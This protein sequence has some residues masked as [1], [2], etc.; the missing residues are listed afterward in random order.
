MR[1][2]RG[3]DGSKSDEIARFRARRKGDEHVSALA[4]PDSLSPLTGV[5]HVPPQSRV[6]SRHTLASYLY[7]P[8][9]AFPSASS[10][11]SPDFVFALL[12][13]PRRNTTQRSN[14][15][16]FQLLRTSRNYH[17]KI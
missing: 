10:F 8:S 16:H 3:F 9:S 15:N 11:L 5:L 1:L 17:C 13:L 14:S 6:I 4:C 7:P 12:I 2:A